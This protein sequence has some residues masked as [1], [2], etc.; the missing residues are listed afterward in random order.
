MLTAGLALSACSDSFLDTESKTESSTGNFYKTENDAYRALVGCYDGWQCTTSSS[1][2]G[3]YLASEMMADECFAGTGNGDDRNYSVIDRFDISQASAYTNLFKTD[4]ANYYAA[5]Y[6]CN[7]LIMHELDINWQSSRT[8]N[9]YMGEC[10]AL[11]AINYFDMVR[12]WENIPLLTE[13]TDANVAQAD[14]H[15]VYE[16][17]L[18]DLKFAAD[19]IPAD[20]YPKAQ[21]D[22]NDGHITCYAAKALLARVYLFYT[23][24]YDVEPT[25]VTKEEVLQGLEDIIASE[26]YDLLP[27][28]KDLWPA[29]SAKW[30]QDAS[31]NWACE[32]NYKRGNQEILLAQKFNYTQD[33]NG[34]NDGNRWLVMVG[35]RGINFAPYGSGWGACTVNPKFFA[36]FQAGDTRRAASII[37]IVS[38]G[39]TAA[40]NYASSHFADQREWTG[41][42]MKKYT[43]MSKYVQG[44]DGSWKL[45]YEVAGLGSGDF[46]ISQYQDF[47]VMRY[48]DVL[49]M[50]AELGSA[51]AQY[52]LDRVRER[53]F[54]E[55]FVSVAPTKENIMNERMYEF[56]FEGQRYW[57]LLRQGV[58]YAASQIAESGCKV[59]SGGNEDIV[60]INADDIK[61]KRG[62]CQIPADEITLSNYVLN[63]NEGW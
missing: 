2:V 15:D 18:S 53:A 26:E 55:N 61:S 28:F 11:R 39:V 38:E 36:K 19:S 13:P 34:N 45:E 24:Y 30:T 1:S 49:L 33:Y 43:P 54:G 35:L 41:Y 7:E 29:A 17:I 50:A 4:W 59:S 8:R 22:Q 63:Q 32:S 9:T 3:F 60:I 47:V 44:D 37:D 52:Y 48:S 51:R 31:G 23:G 40:D 20:A 16:L 62:F 25:V 21:A 58:D 42:A 5:I 6:R 12:L 46:Q 57:D 27:A 56:A 14:P 10:R